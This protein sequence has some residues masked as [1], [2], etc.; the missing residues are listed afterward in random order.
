MSQR[1]SIA[2]KGEGQHKN[3][4]KTHFSVKKK[5]CNLFLDNGST[6]NLVSQNLVDSCKLST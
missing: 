2:P 3:L 6:E 1:M 4:F 5:M